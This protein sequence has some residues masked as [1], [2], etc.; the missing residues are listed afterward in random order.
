[1]RK[2]F[3]VMT[4]IILI[5][6]L[7]ACTDNKESSDEKKEDSV[8]SVKTAEV[9]KG[10]LVIEKALYGRTAPASTTP[11]MVQS[12]GEITTLEV[13]NGDIVE[14]DDLIATIETARGTQN[15]Y[16]STNGEIANLKADEG[17][18]VS[19]S[20]PLAIIADFS[21]LKLKFTVTANTLDLFKKGDTFTSTIDQKEYKAEIT[22]TSTLP[23][24]TGLYPVEAT[25]ENNEE[26]ILAGMVAI[27]H[28]PEK[29]VKDTMIVPTAAVV[30]ESS[31]SFIFVVKA[32]KV[33][34]VNVN[35]KES[36]S[37]KTAIKGEVKQGAHVVTKGMLTLTDG[38]KVDVVKEGE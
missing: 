19:N 18:M 8:T 34:K 35:V 26:K 29:R 16:A 15:I 27:M 13:E 36:Q 4:A 17:S 11:V 32:N 25:V 21:T 20:E 5:G 28:V 37:D 6:I 10:D 38:S 2:L 24:D 33:T 23:N 1:M 3:L 9:M 31:Q 14:E 30:R 22:S 12:P 7:A